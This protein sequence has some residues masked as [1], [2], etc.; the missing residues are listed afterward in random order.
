[1]RCTRGSRGVALRSTRRVVG[2]D[3]LACVSGETASNSAM[4]PIRSALATR[5]ALP[6]QELAS[7]RCMRAVWIARQ[8]LAGYFA[9][10]RRVARARESFH[11]S[12]LGF[13]AERA[14]RLL[15]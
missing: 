10:T 1:M 12:P 7:Q 15:F 3:S 6:C 13:S 9:G 11:E 5:R 2:V 4:V 14:P 8:V